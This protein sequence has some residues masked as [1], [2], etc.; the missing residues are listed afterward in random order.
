MNLTDFVAHHTFELDGL[1]YLRPALTV[2]LYWSTDDA[3]PLGGVASVLNR[4]W[5]LIQ[6]H[7][8]M[9]Q[10]TSMKKPKKLDS[11]ARTLVADIM[12]GAIEPGFG[13]L[14]IDDRKAAAAAAANGMILTVAPYRGVGYVVIK[15]TPDFPA[16][17]FSNELFAGTNAMRYLNGFA[18][19]GLVYNE[20]G[21]LSTDAEQQLFA[22]GMRYPGLDLQSHSNTSFVAQSGLKCVNW[23]TF[24]GDSLADGSGLKLIEGVKGDLQ[25]R[26]QKYGWII[27]AGP[28]PC[29]GDVNRQNTCPVYAQAGRLLASVR[30]LSHP[31]FILDEKLP[32]GSRERTDLWLS[33]FDS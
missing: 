9:Y 27:Q 21:E 7:M 2:N 13:T 19:P 6:P 24:V 1:T 28:A 12:A 22:L 14:I 8:S 32:M 11:Q 4:F 16:D 29:I 18:G 33:R 26:R 31:A 3:G 15:V 20:L 10:T 5:P 30:A 23:L 17:Q 25:I